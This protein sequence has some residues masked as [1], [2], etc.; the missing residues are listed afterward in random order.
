MRDVSPPVATVAA[1]PGEVR[2]VSERVCASGK[3]MSL[4]AI[5]YCALCLS[6]EGRSVRI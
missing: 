2:Q 3:E 4:T 5:V 6:R 1:A